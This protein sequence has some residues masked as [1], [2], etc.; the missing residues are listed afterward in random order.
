MVIYSAGNLFARMPSGDIVWLFSLGEKMAPGRVPGSD[1]VPSVAVEQAA[2]EEGKTVYSAYCSSCHGNNGVGSQ[3][4]GPNITV[5]T[6][7]DVVALAASEGKGK[8]PFFKE[9]LS[10]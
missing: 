8:I 2:I 4:V 3:G 5:V 7:A 9:I 1:F 6:S 10:D